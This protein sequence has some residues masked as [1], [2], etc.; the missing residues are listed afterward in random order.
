MEHISTFPLP[1][2]TLVLGGANT[3]FGPFVGAAVFLFLESVVSTRTEHWPL[4]VGIVFV[5]FILLA[6]QGLW[7]TLVGRLR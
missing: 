3:F 5:L 6:R 1:P 2:V 4:V 7:G